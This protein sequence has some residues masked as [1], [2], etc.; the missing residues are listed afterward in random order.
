MECVDCIL[1]F[2]ILHYT[3]IVLYPHYLTLVSTVLHNTQVTSPLCRATCH[4]GKNYF[5]NTEK[6]LLG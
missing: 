2:Y 4:T 6:S 3:K 5:I 1:K